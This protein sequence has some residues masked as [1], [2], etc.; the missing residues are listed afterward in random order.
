MTALGATKYVYFFEE[1]EQLRDPSHP[2][3]MKNMLGGKGA[4]LAE[5]T[6]AGL[7]VPS[8]FTITTQACLQFYEAGGAFPDGLQS[9]I[10]AAMRKLEERTGK[11][12]GSVENPLLVSVRSGARVS[13]P[14]MM[15]T[16]LNLGLNDETVATLARLTENDRFAWDAYRRFVMMFSNVVLGIGKENFEERID[17]AKE[18]RGARNDA[19]LDAAAWR[20]LVGEFKTIVRE[21]TGRE[22]PQDVREQLQGAIEAVFGS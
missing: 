4:G 13:M 17:A 2:S 3:S 20:S 5:M 16:I 8:G 15:D 14:G 6:A 11:G 18:S 19:G 1:G 12:F 22:F 10:D 9:Q 7:P 21:R